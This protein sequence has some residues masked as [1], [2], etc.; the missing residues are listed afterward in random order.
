MNQGVESFVRSF[1]QQQALD[2][3][4]HTVWKRGV[5]FGF[6]VGIGIGLLINGLGMILAMILLF[7]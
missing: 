5:K 3:A 4:F 2:A 7:K 6:L 1:N